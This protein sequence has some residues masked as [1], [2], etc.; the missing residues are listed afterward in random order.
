MNVRLLELDA[1]Y[2]VLCGWWEKRGLTAPSRIILEGAHG[3]AVKA[4]SVDLCAGWLYVSN[5]GIVGMV[6][7]V[8]S[9]PSVIDMYAMGN[10]LHVLYDFFQTF[11]VKAGCSV[12]FTSTQGEG[13]ISKFLQKHKWAVCP[14]E[15]HVHLLKEIA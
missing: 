9:N 8:I 10:A 13:S 14:G 6:E 15:P 5:K 11:A 1:D 2:P 3:V 12:L 7:W 4:G